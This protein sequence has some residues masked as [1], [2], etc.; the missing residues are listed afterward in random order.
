M[1]AS[2]MWRLMM[3]MMALL[4]SC[5]SLPP[6]TTRDD[7]LRQQVMATERAFAKTMADRDFAAFKTFIA[8][9][10]V[11]FSG[12]RTLRG[13]QQ[14]SDAWQRLYA[15][16]AVPFSWVPEQ[17]EVLATGNLALSS[18]P[19]LDPTGKPI[20]TFMSIWRAESPGVWRIVFDKGNDI[21]NCA[22]PQ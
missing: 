8:D 3:I 5:A 2:I 21:C 17:V 11:F 15:T 16:P 12:T 7:E 18:G 9:D 13:K 22:T 6:S 10:A 19:V 4:A 14:V 1:R 20:A